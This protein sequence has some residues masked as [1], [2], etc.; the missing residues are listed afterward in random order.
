VLAL[1]AAISSN[2]AN[3]I[4]QMAHSILVIS[5]TISGLRFADIAGNIE[6]GAA[7][8][9]QETLMASDEK[10]CREMDVLMPALT[11]VL[12]HIE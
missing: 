9:D 4:K 10:L 8:M 11:L 12:E 3:E 2:D 6:H 5:A 1:K 7:T